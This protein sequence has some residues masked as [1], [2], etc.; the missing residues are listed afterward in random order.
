M[1][2]IPA[3][4]WVAGKLPLPLS[5][6]GFRN[7]GLAVLGA[8]LAFDIGT[9]SYYRGSVVTPL[10]SVTIRTA[11]RT[12]PP[13]MASAHINSGAPSAPSRLTWPIRH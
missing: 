6:K 5:D 3:F 4:R 1:N 9:Y 12:S 11:R 8:V 7:V 10:C 13:V 2:A